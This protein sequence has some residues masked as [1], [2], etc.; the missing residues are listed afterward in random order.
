MGANDT[1]IAA[2]KTLTV[3][4]SATTG[5][6]A[7][8]ETLTFTGTASETDGFLN[9]TGGAGADTIVGAAAA[10]TI[11]GGAAADSITG[12]LGADSLTG[13]DA[14]DTFVYSA[15]AQS[16]SGTALDTITDFTTGTNKLEVTL[17]Y[18]GLG[19]AATV[20]ATFVT[21]AA[22]TTAVQNSLSG[23]RGQYIYD[24]TN[25][26]IIVNVNNDNLISTLD[27][28]IN[29]STVNA[30]GVGLADGDINF[31]ITGGAGGDTITAGG[32]VDTISGGAGAD[33]ITG[34]SGTDS[35]VGGAGADTIAGGTGADTIT[36][37]T[38]DDSITG[39]AGADTFVL[40]G[41]A[42]GG[43]DS[44][45]FI[46][47]D[48]D[49]L[50]LAA[51]SANIGGTASVAYVSGTTQAILLMA[52]VSRSLPMQ[53]PLRMPP[54]VLPRLKW[55]PTLVPTMSSTAVPPVTLFTSWLMTLPILICSFLLRVLMRPTAIPTRTLMPLTTL[56]SSLLASLASLMQLALQTQWS[57]TSQQPDLL[58]HANPPHLMG[59]FFLSFIFTVIISLILLLH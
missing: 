39:G 21:A 7:T 22:G 44:I 18:S 9:I 58:H 4:A 45:T 14:G 53:L 27:Y 2:G 34:G 48:T 55:R 11:S 3:D 20:N 24:T 5:L 56:V 15:V 49:L 50:S 43:R 42:A 10:D 36:G 38:G 51:N 30:S 29:S 28:Q 35:L 8:A 23:E 6:A 59:G 12:G 57:S 47:S 13:G 40:A 1:Q 25:N 46:E 33:S 37:G 26:K 41:T 32:G 16:S 17:D 52:S 31:S 54:L 19:S